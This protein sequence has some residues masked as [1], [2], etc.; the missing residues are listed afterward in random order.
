MKVE[1][2]PRIYRSKWT[3]LKSKGS[4]GPVLTPHIIVTNGDK[5]KAEA[6]SEALSVPAAGEWTRSRRRKRWG[7]GI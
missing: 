1:K 5:D 2:T 7:E 6:G 4:P 3:G